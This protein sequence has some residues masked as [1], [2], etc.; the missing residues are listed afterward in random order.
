[1]P[2]RQRTDRSYARKAMSDHKHSI[3]RRGEDISL[4]ELLAVPLR[5]I[6]MILLLS[7]G[8]I[9]LALVA[10]LFLPVMYRATARILPPQ[11]QGSGLQS[12]FSPGSGLGAAAGILLGARSSADVYVGILKSRNVADTLIGVFN[13]KE[14]YGLNTMEDVYMKLADRTDVDISGKAQIINISVEDRDPRRAANMANLYVEALDRVNRQVNVTEGQRKREFLEDRLASVTGDLAK[15]EATLKEFQQKYKLVAVEEQ[16]RSVIEGAAKLKAELIAAETELEVLRQFRTERQSDAVM[17]KAKI[18]ELGRQLAR[19][20]TGSKD[21]GPAAPGVSAG[22]PFSISF[23][24][25]PELSMKLGRLLREAKVQEKVFELLTAQ[26]EMAKLE[27][28]RDMNTIQVLDRA[29]P[30][31][32]KSSPKR[33]VIASLSAGSVFLIAVF[34]AYFLEYMEFIRTTDPDRYRVFMRALKP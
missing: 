7:V 18:A 2:A 1:L 16:A 27:E 11:E 10:S 12:F 30:P 31:D 14:L 15:A 32:K 3:L 21:R 19:L 22:G 24:E 33:M 23:Q 5:R 26:Y 34:L 6:R 25:I 8:G 4:L 9:A 29:L 17:L 20:E 13:L 28:A